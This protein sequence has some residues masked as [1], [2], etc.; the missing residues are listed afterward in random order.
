VSFVEVLA[1]EFGP[2]D[3]L[4]VIIVAV[5]IYQFMVMAKGTRAIQIMMGVAIMGIFSWLGSLYHLQT[6]TWILTSFFDS[7][8]IILVILFQDQIRSALASFASQGRFFGGLSRE[9]LEQEIDEVVEATRIMGKEKVGALIVFER[10][11]GLGNFIDSGTIIDSKIHSDLIYAIFS[12]KASFHD[13]AIIISGG[14]LRSVGCFLPLAKN[15]DIEKSYGTRHRAALGITEVTDAVVLVISEES[16]K[17]RICANGRFHNVEDSRSLRV[18]L[19]H[20]WVGNGRM[21]NTDG[22]PA[23]DFLF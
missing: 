2:K 7:F 21:L 14:L 20:L 6:L 10:G 3:L 17:V 13:G 4:D 22:M 16:G 19:K 15:I 12:S 23:G 18:F 11:Q 8:I 9:K 5:V 1:K